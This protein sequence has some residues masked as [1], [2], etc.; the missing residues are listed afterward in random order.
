MHVTGLFVYPIK[1]CGGVSLQQAEVTRS[2]LRHDRR[3]M[4]VD[5]EGRFLSQRTHP[6]L[7]R[8]TTQLEPGGVRAR[9]P[10]G[11]LFV[12][13]HFADAAAEA[14][15]VQVWRDNLD[16]VTHA[17]GSQFFRDVLALPDVSL[18][19]L[20]PGGE[21]VVDPRFGQAE[22][23]VTFADAYPLLLMGDASVRDLAERA[24]VPLDMRRFRP[25]MTFEGAPYVED[26]MAAFVA[27]ELPFRGVKRCDRCV[28]TTLD[29]DTQARGPEP[30]RTLAAYRRGADGKVYLGMNIIPDRE[31][32]LRVGDPLTSVLEQEPNP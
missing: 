26:R 22:D 16:A 30:L 18:V 2:G 32:V 3:L 9:S 5:A 25:N 23:R 19:A 4:V 7:G 24:G 28:L 11:E 27:G 12:P 1:S 6:R 21:R 15:P 29:P 10:E 17:E 14:R 13:F 31:G 20:P 8:V